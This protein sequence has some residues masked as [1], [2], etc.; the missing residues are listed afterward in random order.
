MATTYEATSFTNQAPARLVK[1]GLTPRYEEIDPATLVI[2]DVFKFFYVPNGVRIVNGFLKAVG[3]TGLD[4][5]GAPTLTAKVEIVDDAGTTVLLATSSGVRAAN[6]AV[7]F[8]SNLGYL[9]DSANN[10][11]YL[12]VTLPAAAATAGTS[13]IGLY[14]EWSSYSD[15]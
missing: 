7:R 2:N 1:I 3:G 10:D 4:T 5:N 13:N 12:K 8:D 15:N 11:A 6:A 14:A 9:V